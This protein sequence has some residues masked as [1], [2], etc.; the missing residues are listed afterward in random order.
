MESPA[1]IAAT[2]QKITDENEEHIPEFL[3]V[4]FRTY[5]LFHLGSAEMA[6]TKPTE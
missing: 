2:A 1:L 4:S 3:V 5:L 6:P